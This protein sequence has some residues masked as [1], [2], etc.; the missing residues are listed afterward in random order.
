MIC[1]FCNTKLYDTAPAGSLKESFLLFVCNKCQPHEVVY[2]ELYDQETNELLADAI[3]LDEYLI[4][5]NYKTNTTEFDKTIRDN[6]LAN[7]TGIFKMDGI[8]KIPTTTIEV[9]KQKISLYTVFS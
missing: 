4:V 2:R 1:N 6:N 8:W 3:R 9:V 7:V 5:R